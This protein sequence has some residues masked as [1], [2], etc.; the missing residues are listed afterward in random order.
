MEY[1]LHAVGVGVGRGMLSGHDYC[2]TSGRCLRGTSADM[3]MGVPRACLDML[4]RE[5]ETWL[6]ITCRCSTQQLRTMHGVG[7][8]YDC[9]P[10]K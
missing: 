5:M 4:M 2:V 8:W 6:I 9:V 7:A 1:W 10:E 3:Q